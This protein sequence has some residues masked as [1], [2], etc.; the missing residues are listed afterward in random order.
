M[1]RRLR[2]A[3]ALAVVACGACSGSSSGS[4][5]H[6]PKL[7]YST[8]AVDTT[9]TAQQYGYSPIRDSRIRYQPDLVLIPNGASAIRGVSANG[10]SWTMDRHVS[11][12]DSL[13]VGSVM[14]ATSMAVGR[15]AA[16]DDAATT[17]TVTLAP[18]AL[19]DI[20]RD[21]SIHSQQAVDESAFGSQA[22]PDFPGGVTAKPSL[23]TPTTRG[24][25]T[26]AEI[27]GA[28]TID[29]ARTA[30]T[31]SAL[32]PSSKLRIKT[33]LGNWELSPYAQLHRL[34]VSINYE[35]NAALKASAIF[36][37]KVDHLKLDYG[38]D[39]HNAT[40]RRSDFKLTGLK[41][42]EI[43]IAAGVANGV[44]DNAKAQL[45]TPIE[46]EI[47]VPPSRATFGMPLT[48]SVTFKVDI[49]T[50]LSGN[51]STLTA[52]G[53]YKLDGPIGFSGTSI[54]RPTFSVEQSIIDSIGGIT[55]GPSG[56]VVGV[57]AKFTF[58][59]GTPAAP[60]G[61]STTLATTF[62]VTNG[63]SLAATFVRCRGATL[64]MQLKTGVGFF[65]SPKF[66]AGLQRLLPPKTPLNSNVEAST[67]L[68]H[69][70]QTIPAVPLCG[71]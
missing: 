44:V 29:F 69:R 52:H 66:F 46:L 56:I 53:K 67:V 37:I 61:F 45:E 25:V 68:L 40:I 12:I 7:H 41:G 15:V 18:A 8:G 63:S 11:G 62:G 64:D 13:K 35:A 58:G 20:I 6:S 28:P 22:I 19:T 38:L 34:G 3:T 27:S 2:I 33:R 17:R 49:E 71:K 47:A 32:P 39:I 14:F 23:A 42:F 24:S 30:I 50:A 9:A 26:T 57:G 51:N 59:L 4:A 10:L 21:G 60:V 36:A 1:S 48:L 70:S 31:T 16:I 65:V 55:L 54:L 43:G 5:S